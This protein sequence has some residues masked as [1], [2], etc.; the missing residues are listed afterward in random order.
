MRPHNKL[1]CVL[2]ERCC[3]RFEWKACWPRQS[4][5]H[6]WQYVH[7]TFQT[8]LRVSTRGTNLRHPSNKE[9][10]T[11]MVLSDLGRSLLPPA[12]VRLKLQ[13]AA[14]WGNETNYTYCLS[15]QTGEVAYEFAQVE[16]ARTL[17]SQHTDHSIYKVTQITT[18]INTSTSSHRS[19]H[20]S[21]HRQAHTQI[22]AGNTITET[23]SMTMRTIIR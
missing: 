20:R 21:A 16:L 19:S 17:R 1:I 6:R 3:K 10:S 12:T 18:Q 5:L 11:E 13:L 15:S 8:M 4:K 9:C 2:I 7:E 23:R 22:G 14:A